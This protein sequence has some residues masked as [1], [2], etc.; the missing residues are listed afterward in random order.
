MIQGYFNIAESTSLSP[1][2]EEG[3][4]DWEQEDL[5]ALDAHLAFEKLGLSRTAEGMWRLFSDSKF[6]K[7][8]LAHLLAYVYQYK[9]TANIAINFAR[10]KEDFLGT[11][12]EPNSLH[13]VL[14]DPQADVTPS[15]QTLMLYRRA[16]LEG[17]DNCQISQKQESYYS[18]W[19]STNSVN[20]N[21]VPS[22]SLPFGKEYQGLAEGDSIQSFN[23]IQM[24]MSTLF[25]DNSSVFSF[26]QGQNIKVLIIGIPRGSVK[27]FQRK[28]RYIGV[29]G[30]GTI[31]A[32]SI[33]PDYSTVVKIKIYRQN[34]LYP[35]LVFQPREFI[36]DTNLF[37][38]PEDQPE[39][40][41]ASAGGIPPWSAVGWGDVDVVNR[42]R[43]YSYG[44]SPI[45]MTA[46][47][48]R[49]D[50]S[51][52]D[53]L[54]DEAPPHTSGG[55]TPQSFDLDTLSVYKDLAMGGN[56]NETPLY[57]MLRNECVSSYL[58]HYYKVL[59][60]VQLG[61]ENYKSQ[62]F[63]WTN[64]MRP[65]QQAIN[66]LTYLAD[67]SSPAS[68]E[69]I[70]SGGVLPGDLIANVQY[71]FVPPPGTSDMS[72]IAVACTSF[73]PGIGDA[74]LPVKIKGWADPL[75]DPNNTA[76]LAGGGII[77]T[78]NAGESQGINKSEH[79]NLCCMMESTLFQTGRRY[80]NSLSNTLF[81]RVYAIPVDL[82]GW[83]INP[84]ADGQI[85]TNAL[86]VII[87]LGLLTKLGTDAATSAGFTGNSDHYVFSIAGVS[88][89]EAFALDQFWAEFEL[90]PALS[91]QQVA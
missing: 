48:W 25:G 75:P 44:L 41:S 1:H 19:S 31:S 49:K 51:G 43:Y 80:F 85:S 12:T 90:V 13:N 38:R 62:L 76:V 68:S 84:G 18:S 77:Q 54:N 87:D 5:N 11:G 64:D 4:M 33:K 83:I 61:A 23:S 78:L 27:T 91:P 30:G 58:M 20:N 10:Q 14:H 73:L 79:K 66:L 65:D 82:D 37:L 60:G 35:E 50:S 6:I 22:T 71:P 86:N 29:G 72:D 3:L 32:A 40:D 24:A 28:S 53:I 47:T 55:V 21:V 8:A 56:I 52:N 45:G 59:F 15:G 34:M 63:T 67:P 88:E 57:Y 26:P 74:Q 9:K 42:S 81:D 16:I 39:F 46:T 2:H 69:L 7:D 70:S 36:V 89:Q 17:L